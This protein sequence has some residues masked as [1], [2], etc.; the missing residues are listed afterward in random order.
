VNAT[1]EPSASQQRDWW[2]RA[3]AVFQSPRAVFAAL[4]DDSQPAAIAR[5][6]PI[7]AIVLLAGMAGVLATSV[8]GRLLDDSRFDGLLV[9]VWTFIVGGLY[10]LALYWLGG[11]LLHGAGALL[12]ARST[13]RTARHVLGFAA[14]PL[15]LVLLLVWP[16]RLAVY[17]GDVFRSGGDD[18]GTGDVVFEAVALGFA[19][20]AV[21]LLVIGMRAVHA[22]SLPRA[23]AAVA[24]AATPV[25]L[26]VALSVLY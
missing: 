5:A 10:A 14:A 20:W 9:A 3:L 21:A 1:V 23:A 24:L 18:S 12:G 15:V 8:A 16:V 19:A 11:A 26:V 25:A 13:Y 22:W 4:R 17:G 7:T 6:E 2:L